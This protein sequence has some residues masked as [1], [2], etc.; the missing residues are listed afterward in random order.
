[1]CLVTTSQLFSMSETQHS[2]LQKGLNLGALPD[3]YLII[4]LLME[5]RMLEKAATDV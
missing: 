2:D 1:M 4:F 3:P 5:A